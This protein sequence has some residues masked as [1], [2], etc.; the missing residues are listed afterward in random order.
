MLRVVR[1]KYFTVS[2]F[3]FFILDVNP[4]QQHIIITHWLLRRMQT[5]VAP[6]FRRDAAEVLLA[7]APRHA[8][9]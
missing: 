2:F 3:F 1:A 9:R 6:P 5:P 8:S 4:V 7:G